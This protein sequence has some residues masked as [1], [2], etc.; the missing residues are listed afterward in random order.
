[1]LRFNDH[2]RLVG[3]HAFLS[4]SKYSWL[5]YTDERL[6]DAW[7]THR[8]AAMGTR[9]HALAAEHISLGIRMPR[10][11][12]TLCQYINDAIGYRMTP[13]QV[14]F[15]SPNCFGTVDAICFDERKH[16]LRIHDLKTGTSKASMDQLMVYAALFCL[17][18]D[19]S[20]IDIDFELRIY[21]NDEVT[22]FNPTGE[23]VVQVISKIQHADRIIESLKEME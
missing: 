8:A 7:R 17:E 13:E 10:T 2:G 11:G 1:M 6:E 16:L 23:E 19:Y 20:P 14:L 12:A 22:V 9:L 4:A 21:Q 5:R 15:Y 18:Y 3:E